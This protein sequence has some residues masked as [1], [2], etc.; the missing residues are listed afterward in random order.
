MMLAGYVVG[1]WLMARAALAAA[2]APEQDDFLRGKVT[3]AAFYA[4][5]SLPRAV[6]LAASVQRGASFASQMPIEQF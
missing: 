5:Q 6:S 3:S 4:E 1:G 2:K